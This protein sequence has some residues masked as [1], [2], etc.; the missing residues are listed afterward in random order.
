MED[1]KNPGAGSLLD[2][3]V[4]SVG[5]GIK[6]AIATYPAEA[7][8]SPAELERWIWDELGLPPALLEPS[9]PREGDVARGSANLRGVGTLLAEEGVSRGGETSSIPGDGV[10]GGA[11]PS[12]ARKLGEADFLEL[13][14]KWANVLLTSVCVVCAGLAAGLTMGLVSIE[15][16]EM[17]IKQ[18]SGERKVSLDGLV[19]VCGP[20]GGWGYRRL[21]LV[22]WWLAGAFRER[23]RGEGVVLARSVGWGGWLGCP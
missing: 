20:S 22:W 10:R 8:S 11:G 12:F 19:R 18:R 23:G 3:V 5:V 7:S 9:T 2:D 16:L 1:A 4:W 6:R 13:E 14:G 21:K 15:P 17:E